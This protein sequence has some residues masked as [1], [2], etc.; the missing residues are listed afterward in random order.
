MSHRREKRRESVSAGGRSGG[1]GQQAA[2]DKPGRKSPPALPEPRGDPSGTALGRGALSKLLLF[3]E[4]LPRTL[5][6][7]FLI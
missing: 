6:N 5:P 4:V 1:A 2:P 3:S 7:E